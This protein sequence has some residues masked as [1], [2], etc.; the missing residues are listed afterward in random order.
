[1]DLTPADAPAPG[2][3]VTVEARL[4]EPLNRWLWLVKWF[5][6]IPHIVV[7]VLLW[8]VFVIL[9]VVAG[10]NIVVTGRYPRSIFDFNVGVMRWTWRVQLYAFSLATDRYPPFSLQRDPSYPA[11]LEVEYPEQLSRGLVWIK[12][13]LLAIPHYA[14]VSFFDGGPRVFGL[15]GILALVAGVTLAVKQRYPMSIFDFIMGMHRWEWRVVAYAAL[16]R[17]D[18]PPFR[19]DLGPTEPAPAAPPA[20]PAVADDPT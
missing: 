3:P 20:P 17:D 15:T 10:V 6:A 13:W 8:I 7:L 5:L 1:M 14:I 16:M 12:W 19:I 2:Y 4:D 9:T 18:Y 11:E